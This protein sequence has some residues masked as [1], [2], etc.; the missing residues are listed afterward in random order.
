[1]DYKKRIT[2]AV[3]L[4]K[5]QRYCSVQDRC[6]SEMRTKLYEWGASGE[7][8]DAILASL[9][10][11]RFLDEERYAKSYARGKF[12]MKQWGRIKIKMEL[13]QK[14]IEK[15]N[16]IIGLREIEEEDYRLT[17]QSILQKYYHSHFD[18]DN[19][20]AT[21]KAIQYAI[22]RGFEPELVFEQAKAIEK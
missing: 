8:I 4:A 15:P 9:V 1:M 17:L 22:S 11:D 5:A 7:M 10:A 13:K 6:H 19:Y 2:E 14:G 18:G 3:G 12:R 16:I 21:H 20:Q